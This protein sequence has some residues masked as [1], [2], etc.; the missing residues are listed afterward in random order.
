MVKNNRYY[1][2]NAKS[3]GWGAEIFSL[4]TERINLIKKFVVGKKVLDVGCGFGIYV[5]F[6]S[7]TG[8]EST[9]VDFVSSF[10]ANAK[11]SKKGYF[12]KASADNLP[13]KN[14]AFDTVLLFDILEHGDDTKLLQEAKRV[15]KDRVLVI[16]PMRVDEQLSSSG[17]IFRHYID[18]SHLREYIK[19]DLEKLAK[20]CGLKVLYIE[21]IHPLYNETIFLSLFKGPIILKKIVRK[22]IFFILPKK[23]Y[24]TELFA[25]LEKI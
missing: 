21:N 23:S 8:F 11:R 6:L 1:A 22:I 7:L 17:V 18:K 2:Q 15:C 3:L 4:D 19:D 20:K 25:V 14:E 9:G 5:D 16:V 13:F 10:I 12:I 24:P